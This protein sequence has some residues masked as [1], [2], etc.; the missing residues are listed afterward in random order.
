[1]TLDQS[2]RLDLS[3]IE[4]FLRHDEEHAPFGF[5]FRVLGVCRAHHFESKKLADGDYLV[6][7]DPITTIAEL[8]MSVENGDFGRHPNIGRLTIEHLRRLFA[9]HAGRGWK[10]CL[11]EVRG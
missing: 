1:M 11:V 8:G 10:S 3:G 6:T 2:R 9:T 5:V 7:V 4:R